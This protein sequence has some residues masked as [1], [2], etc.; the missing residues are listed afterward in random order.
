MGCQLSSAASA[1]PLE[2]Y[3]TRN[4]TLNNLIS[5]TKF[6]ISENVRIS[7]IRK[8]FSDIRN[9]ISDIR[10]C[11][12]LLISENISDI[13]NHF[14]ISENGHDFLISE[15]CVFSDIRSSIFWYQILF[16]D[17]R[18]CFLISEILI[19]WYQKIISD[20]R[21]SDFWYKKNRISENRN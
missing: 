1:Q 10:K 15:I 20:I 8:W 7:Y 14:L 9:S 3:G 17:I 19:F 13:R 6:L 5:E 11:H 2:Q 18:N 12:T 16:F 21:K 4:R